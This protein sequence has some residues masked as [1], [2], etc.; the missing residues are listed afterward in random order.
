LFHIL[1][2]FYLQDDADSFVQCLE[3]G[4]VDIATKGIMQL[5]SSFI[6]YNYSVFTSPNPFVLSLV[7]HLSKSDLTKY[8]LLFYLLNRHFEVL[9]LNSYKKRSYPIVLFTY[10]IAT[11]IMT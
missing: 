6:T 10:R 2:T 11:T 4:V 1:S 7:L 5:L 3:A 8:S 9:C